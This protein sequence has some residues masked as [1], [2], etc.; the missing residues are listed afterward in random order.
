MRG[1]LLFSCLLL[2]FSV[3]ARAA[4]VRRATL[5]YPPYSS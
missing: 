4:D 1:L 5:E 3:N 2:G